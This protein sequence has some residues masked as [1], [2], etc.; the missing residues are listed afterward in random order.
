LECDQ[1]PRECPDGSHSELPGS[2]VQP[3]DIGAGRLPT[4]RLEHI[5]DGSIHAIFVSVPNELCGYIKTGDDTY[6]SGAEL[7]DGSH[8]ISVD[9]YNT[10]Y[11]NNGDGYSEAKLAS[12]FA[13]GDIIRS[14][15]LSRDYT[16][17][18]P[19]LT[20]DFDAL[21]KIIGYVFWDYCV[22]LFIL[23]ESVFTA[24]FGE[25]A[26]YSILCDYAD[27][28]ND[29]DIAALSEAE[30]RFRTKFSLRGR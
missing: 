5:A 7:F 16:V 18:A 6:Y 27:D 13:D 14:D 25:S 30:K 11:I 22:Q 21:S 23:P 19:D 9:N 1:W 29:R 4:S 2:K 28:T 3:L 26:I 8:I 24:E 20:Y 12:L 15:T 17:I 10:Y